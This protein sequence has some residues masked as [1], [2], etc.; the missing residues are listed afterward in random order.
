[1]FQL[2]CLLSSEKKKKP[3]LHE[4]YDTNCETYGG[5]YIKILK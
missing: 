4:C 2:D 5:S 3:G 1:M